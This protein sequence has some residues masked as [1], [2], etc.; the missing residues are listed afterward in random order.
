MWL[1]M[2]FYVACLLIFIQILACRLAQSQ[3]FFNVKCFSV[4]GLKTHR[5]LLNIVGNAKDTPTKI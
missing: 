2:P 4:T 3:T 5:G 1:A